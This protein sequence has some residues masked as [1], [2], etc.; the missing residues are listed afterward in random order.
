MTIRPVLSLFLGLS[1][2][3]C[4]LFGQQAHEHG[5]SHDEPKVAAPKIFLDKSPRIVAYQLQRLS[6]E[7]LLAVERETTDAKFLPVFKAIVTREGMSRANR[8]EALAALV[9][10]NQ[11]D[12]VAE[13]LTTLLAVF[14][15]APQDEPTIDGLATLLLQQAPGLLQQHK[16]ELLQLGMSEESRLSEVAYAALITADEAATAELHAREHGRLAQWL[17]GI[18]RVPSQELRNQLHPQVIELTAA[19]HP[20]DIRRAALTALSTV[21]AKPESTFRHAAA[22]VAE[23][24]LQISAVHALLSTPLDAR[25]ADRSLELIDWLLEFAERT[26]PAGRTSEPFLDAMEL[27]DQ[28]IRRAPTEQARDFR[29]RLRETVVRV[30]RIHAIEEEMRY[31]LPY[32]AVEAGRPVQ[33]VLVND[34]LMPHN[35]VVTSPGSLIKV[36][37]EGQVVGPEGGQDGKQYVPNSE[38]VLFATHMVPARQQ[39]TLTFTAPTVPGEYPYV[40][41]FPRHWMRMYGVMVVVE[42]LDAWSKNPVEP[43][44]P[45]GSNRQFVQAWSIGDFEGKLERGMRGG[46]RAIGE[47][48][49]IEATCAQCHKLGQVGIGNVGPALDDVFAR[50]KGDALVVLQEILDPSHRIDEKYAVNLVL[51]VDGQTIS[52]IVVEENKQQLV[53]LDNP[54]SEKPTVI[55]Q[56]EI[57]QRIKTST[58]MMPKGLLDRFSETEIYEI[59][60]FIQ[61][62]QK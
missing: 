13:L 42:D 1:W 24:E 49:F 15:D 32:F 44:D 16:A 17:R 2:L 45:I 4:P 20:T 57:E 25:D 27:V 52:G 46:S 38:E 48:L 62:Q 59:L 5:E 12:P 29:A 10:L 58:S 33:V 11:S 51:T 40:C 31:D 26:P 47:R 54:E 61:S 22:L 35:L 37:E 3:W 6:N 36:A 60:S 23:S 18:A 56:D 41:T 39:E 14:A 30:V 28:L 8:E 9:K 55:A 7:Q 19:S 53:I 34:D 43:K 21:S 50:W